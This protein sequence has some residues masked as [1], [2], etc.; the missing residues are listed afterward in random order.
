M[1]EQEPDVRL[2]GE[3]AAGMLQPVVLREETRP[4]LGPPGFQPL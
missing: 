1:F 4:R 3:L 2:R